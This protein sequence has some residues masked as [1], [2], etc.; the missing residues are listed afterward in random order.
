MFIIGDESSKN[1][2]FP[3]VTC[4]LILL[5]VL[6]FCLQ[7]AIGEPLTY[8][9]SLVPKEITQLKDL[10]RPEKV[11]VK[12]LVPAYYDPYYG[13]YGPARIRE[14]SVDVP[15][16]H[17]PFPIVLTLL[18]S[19]FLHGSW[20]HLIGNIWFLAVFGRNVESALDHGRFLWFYLI[21]GTIG[22]L[23]QALTDPNSVIPCLGASGAISGI[24]GAYVAVFPLNKIKMWF[25]WWIGVVEAPA[26][27]VIGIWF[28]W[29]YVSVFTEME[30]GKLGGG[31]IAYW[32]HIGGF[33]SGVLIIW[34]TIAFLKWKLANAPQDSVQETAA[35]AGVAAATAAADD[36]FS[37][38]LPAKPTGPAP[39][40]LP[41]RA[42]AQPVAADPFA[43]LLPDRR[44]PAEQCR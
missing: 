34:G 27:V 4:S 22:G 14:V 39:P 43:T 28:L 38:V 18:T 12:M 9:F 7:Q 10:T 32:D 2:R 37:R 31:G 44:Q 21:C 11:K 8:G 13:D 33:L 29:Q 41:Q 3:W 6:A 25:G 42:P 40:E 17:G 15:Q 30:M 16:Y 24:M 19:M 35:E 36:P 23:C 26:L 1:A 5:N 20:A